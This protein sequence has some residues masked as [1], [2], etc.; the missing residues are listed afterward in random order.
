M[1]YSFA[2]TFAYKSNGKVVATIVEL[3]AATADEAGPIQVPIRGRI[4]RVNHE[5]VSGAGT[6]LD[7]EWGRKPGWTASTIDEVAADNSAAPAVFI[8]D[9]E[10]VPYFSRNGQLFLRSGV[11]AGADNK[12]VTEIQIVPEAA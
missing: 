2:V 10:E 9:T 12:I 8:S 7:P 3:E 4:K 1:A 6:T 5:L 11:D